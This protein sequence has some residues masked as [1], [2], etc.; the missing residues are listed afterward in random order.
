MKTL[1]SV[2]LFFFSICLIGQPVN[3]E[4]LAINCDKYVLNPQ[5]IKINFN[6][7]LRYFQLAE[8]KVDIP[9]GLGVKIRGCEKKL[10]VVG[11]F[12][13]VAADIERV[14]RLSYPKVK[15]PKIKIYIRDIRVL[16]NLLPSLNPRLYVTMD[17]YVENFKKEY[18][19]KYSTTGITEIVKFIERPLGRLIKWILEDFHVEQRYRNSFTF[20]DTESPNEKIKGIYTSFVDFKSEKP[21]YKFKYEVKEDVK[22]SLKAKYYIL[23]EN[24][25]KVKAAFF[26]F[27]D[28]EKSFLNVR[29][30]YP[31]DYYVEIEMITDDYYFIYD[32]IYDYSADSNYVAALGGGALGSLIS[33]ASTSVKSLGL[34]NRNTGEFKTFRRKQLKTILGDKFEN[35]LNLKKA[36]DRKGI[37]DLFKELLSDQEMKRKLEF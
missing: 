11:K 8:V 26:A 23:D 14:I 2:L 21:L 1:I 34:I 12:G 33:S 10:K 25:K 30:Y 5:K 29:H 19:L 36:E 28:G 7:E 35:Y 27:N 37:F 17:F 16:Y 6:H 24:G 20:K 4:S 15:A 32:R 13:T 3:K 22:D 9:D 18:E 31:G